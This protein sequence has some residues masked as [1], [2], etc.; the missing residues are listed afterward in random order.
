MGRGRGWGGDRG[1][2]D[3]RGR[4]GGR[5]RGDG[6]GFRGGRGGGRGGG[7]SIQVYSSVFRPQIQSTS[8][9]F[10]FT[11]RPDEL[12]PPPSPAVAKT[13]DV[14]Q[15][16]ISSGGGLGALRLDAKFPHRPGYGTRGNEV[17]LWANYF[18]MVP[19]PN[20]LLYR[21]NVDVQPAATGKKLGQIINLLLQLPEY[22]GFRNDIVTDFKS[23]LVSRRRLSPELA[24]V[25]VTYRAEGEDEPR[26]NAQDYRLRV[27]QTGT[28]TVS[29]LTD[30]LTSTNMSTAY[31]DKLPV[32][33]ALNIF[34]GHYAKSSSMIATAGSSKSFSLHPDSPKLDLGAG[35]SALRGFFSSVRVA[36]CRILVNVNISHGAFYSA[37]RLDLLMQKHA[38][39]HNYNRVKM[40]SF[41]KRLRV[42]ATHL[43]EKKNKTGESI[44][45]VKTIFGLAN[46]ADGRGLPN[47]PQVQSF[48]AGARDVR[49]FL[50]NSSEAPSSS[51]TGQAAETSASTKKGKGKKSP[52]QSDPQGGRYISVFDYFNNGICSVTTRIYAQ[53]TKW[54]VHGRRIADPILPVLNVGNREH[55]SYLPA[56]VCIVLPGQYSKSKLGS[57]QTQ[58]MIRFAV[59]KA[60]ENA[61]SITQ[62]GIRT[63]GLLP[64]ANVNLVR[65]FLPENRRPIGD[66]SRLTPLGSFWYIGNH[67]SYYGT[68]TC[69]G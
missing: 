50:D 21:Y 45:R 65:S 33:Q 55:P 15:Q 24:Q 1:G 37:I 28:L 20:L 56:E 35:L 32:L 49:F 36:T 54:I 64:Q 19:G 2:Y 27:G 10:I 38:T 61:N 17:I 52:G 41:L 48:G 60:W 47:P 59:R 39:A 8:T 23:T 43:G 26:A 3:N 44:P 42:K 13:E 63:V 51:S 46:S 12:I 31:A 16:N 68:G 14:F 58:Q 34:L 62:E 53:L 11:S 4:G 40:E 22:R 18:E 67:E 9:D 29:E 7:A 66:Q 25:T 57:G 5:G 6:Q 30:H 69:L